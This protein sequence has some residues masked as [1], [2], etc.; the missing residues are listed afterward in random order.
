M[1]LKFVIPILLAAPWLGNMAQAGTPQGDCP[2]SS[3]S[4]TQ[5][6]SGR[7]TA[8]GEPFRPDGL[9]AAHR[10]LRFGTRLRVTN[11]R[12]GASAVVVLYDAGPD[13]H[14]AAD[15]DGGAVKDPYETLGVAPD[16]SAEDIRKAYRRLAKKLHP[17][18]IR[19]TNNGSR[20]EQYFLPSLV[21][22]ISRAAACYCAVKGTDARARK[23]QSAK[24]PP[25]PLRS[26]P[27]VTCAPPANCPVTPMIARADQPSST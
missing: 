16:A 2:G 23:V 4:A 15:A 17:D 25:M 18:L 14:G 24:L 10:S 7:H 21:G 13:N 19:L 12:T 26:P 27:T 5:Y 8:S 22:R 11:P 9:T 20:T 1:A 3:M 6:S